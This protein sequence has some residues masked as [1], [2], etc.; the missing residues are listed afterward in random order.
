MNIYYIIALV[1]ASFVLLLFLLPK[2][3]HRQKYLGSSPKNLA[4]GE[5]VI[6]QGEVKHWQVSNPMFESHQ[7][8]STSPQGK[9][10]ILTNRRFLGFVKTFSLTRAGYD[11]Y[12][13]AVFQK[14]QDTINWLDKS[15]YWSG[16]YGI[17]SSPE[18]VSIESL[19]KSE[20]EN[21]IT[22]HVMNNPSYQLYLYGLDDEIV[23]QWKKALRN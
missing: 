21:K 19:T 6:F 22:F 12:F 18:M 17:A 1:V 13:G 20:K 9:Y 14:Q 4:L 11:M 23:E 16:L 15:S 2:P 5:K 10:I 3:D 7:R 8:K